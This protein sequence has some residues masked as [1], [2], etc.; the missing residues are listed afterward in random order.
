MFDS[1]RVRCAS[2]LFGQDTCRKETLF[3]SVLSVVLAFHS[4]SGG[5]APFLVTRSI[6]VLS[7]TSCKFENQ[8]VLGNLGSQ[9]ASCPDGLGNGTKGQFDEIF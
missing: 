9:R 2:T 6:Y 8:R 3:V 5:A 4:R 1:G 7:L